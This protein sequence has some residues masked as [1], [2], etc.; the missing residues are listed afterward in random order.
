MGVG[1]GFLALKKPSSNNE[2]Y[3]H[4]LAAKISSLLWSARSLFRFYQAQVSPIEE[5]AVCVGVLKDRQ[6][7]I[8][9]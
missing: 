4:I 7:V 6:D 9:R 5:M 2:F 8:E 3:L 1:L